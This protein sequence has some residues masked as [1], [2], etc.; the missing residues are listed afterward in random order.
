MCLK[1]SGYNPKQAEGGQPQKTAQCR[2]EQIQHHRS[3][4]KKLQHP[5]GHENKG[6]PLDYGE[7][8]IYT[9]VGIFCQ[10]CKNTH[11]SKQYNYFVQSSAPFVNS[12]F[13]FL[14]RVCGQENKNNRE[15]IFEGQSFIS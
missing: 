5:V 2:R 12:I 10:Q 14:Y 11:R 9:A 1:K 7:Q 3:E 15:G 8:Q 6:S 4:R 13:R